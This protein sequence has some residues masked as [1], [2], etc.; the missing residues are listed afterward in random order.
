[1]SREVGRT[2]RGV[3]EVT[4]FIS[5]LVPLVISRR[6]PQRT[7]RTVL[8]NVGRIEFPVTHLI[9]EIFLSFE[10]KEITFKSSFKILKLSKL[11]HAESRII[12]QFFKL[13]E[14]ISILEVIIEIQG[15]K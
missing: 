9:F 6:G 15:S 4:S 5:F 14:S 3:S 2:R 8:E 10:G 11:F 12:V 1:M 7:I 13:L